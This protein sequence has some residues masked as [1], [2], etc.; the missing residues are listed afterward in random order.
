MRHEMS[1]LMALFVRSEIRLTQGAFQDLPFM[2]F[3]TEALI[4]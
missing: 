2:S 1:C 4:L 3:A